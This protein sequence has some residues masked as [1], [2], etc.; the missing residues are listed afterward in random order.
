MIAARRLLPVLLLA[1]LGVAPL[2][3][4]AQISDEIRAVESSI[5]KIYT[6]SAAPDYF[7]P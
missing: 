5:I 2:A 4:R 1:L 6:T 7:T 3:A